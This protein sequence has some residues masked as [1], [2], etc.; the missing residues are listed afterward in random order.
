[1]NYTSNEKV[2]NWYIFL[3]YGGITRRIIFYFFVYYL[4]LFIFVWI[5]TAAMSTSAYWVELFKPIKDLLLLWSVPLPFVAITIISFLPLSIIFFVEKSIRKKR[6]KLGL[7]IYKNIE[8]DMFYFDTNKNTF[9]NA[10]NNDLNYWYEL[11]EKGAITS[12]EYESKKQE[13]LKSK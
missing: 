13:L 11:K 8:K 1:M 12:E 2:G 6:K 3:N 5:L 4:P 7:S 10:P 9:N